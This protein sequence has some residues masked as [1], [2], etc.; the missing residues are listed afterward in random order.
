MTLI[1]ALNKLKT[2]LLTVTSNAGH[3]E[4]FEK[5]DKYIVYAEDGQADA[6]HGNNRM[7]A[8]VLTGTVDYFTRTEYDANVLA[9]QKAMSD[10]GIPWRLNS[11]QYEPNTGYIHWEWVWEMRVNPHG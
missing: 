10:A 8:Q 5:T 7:Q 6:I 11:V 2:A 9:I 1:E 4:A 3:Y